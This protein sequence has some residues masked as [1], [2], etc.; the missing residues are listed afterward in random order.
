MINKIFDR[1]PFAATIDQSIYCAHGGIPHEITS[2]DDLNSSIPSVISN[3][4]AE[5]NVS[6]EII[7][8]DPIGP[9]EY[10]KVAEI[11][12]IKNQRNEGIK[13][14]YLRNTRRG[15]AFFYNELATSKFLNENHLTHVIRAHEV[16]KEGYVFFFDKKCTTI[17]SCSHYCGNDNNCA[18]I[19]A[20]NETLG[21]IRIDTVANKPATD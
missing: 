18:V 8:S 5:S 7:W 14:G 1:L 13:E 6:W 9:E 10:S 3:P 17:F 2:I 16:P 12:D 21:I 19:L 11:E 4:E 15:T 20:N